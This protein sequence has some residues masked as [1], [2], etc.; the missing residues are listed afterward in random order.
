MHFWLSSVLNSFV[1]CQYHSINA[2][3]SSSP[4]CSSY[5]KGKRAKLQTFQCSSGNEEALDIKLLSTFFQSSKTVPWLKP[6]VAG[7]SP[8]RTGL[9]PSTVHVR[10]V[11][12]RVTYTGTGF[13]PSILVFPYQYGST[14]APSSSSPTC[15]SYQKDKEARPGNLP[16]SNAFSE[17]GEHWMEQPFRSP[18]GCSCT[19]SKVIKLNSR[20]Q[21]CRNA[22]QHSYTKSC[23]S[24]KI[25]SLP[26]Y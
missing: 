13:S 9:H 21:I 12:Y 1:P 25:R 22:Y 24:V 17:T 3:Y 20:E 4:T 8:R 16:K 7:L 11:V 23:N 10:F 15:C 26:L 5:Q 2:P 18:K 19:L 14:S 6:V